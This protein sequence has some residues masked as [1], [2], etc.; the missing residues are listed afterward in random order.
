VE[1]SRRKVG[2]AAKSLKIFHQNLEGLGVLLGA[3]ARREI[4]KP[5]AALT[6]DRLDGVAPG[7]VA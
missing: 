7:G 2:R 5:C 4:Q 3:S 6:L 1:K